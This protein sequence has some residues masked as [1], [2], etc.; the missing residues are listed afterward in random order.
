MQAW[1]T[2][3]LAHGPPRLI[4]GSKRHEIPCNTHFGSGFAFHVNGY[5]VTQI[6][7]GH[8]KAIFALRHQDRDHLWRLQTHGSIR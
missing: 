8:V 1:L 7:F 3:I 6:G 5:T 2:V 4:L